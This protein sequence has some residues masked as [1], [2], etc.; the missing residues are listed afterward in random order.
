MPP[1]GTVG[2]SGFIGF[3]E[4]DFQKDLMENGDFGKD[5]FAETNQ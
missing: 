1:T 4:K 3:S 5:F 2:K